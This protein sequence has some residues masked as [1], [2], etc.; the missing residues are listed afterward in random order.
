M[1]KLLKTYKV[2]SALKKNIEGHFVAACCNLFAKTGTIIK[3]LEL[4][5]TVHTEEINL[6]AVLLYF[7]ISA[8]LT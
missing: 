5:S 4:S 7:V 3:L 1:F 8:T 6:V 2:N